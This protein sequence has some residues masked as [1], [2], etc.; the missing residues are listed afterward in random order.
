[1]SNIKTLSDLPEDI[2]SKLRG[3]R[4]KLK[5][6]WYQNDS[7]NICFVNNE[8]TRYFRATRKA[9]SGQ[10]GPFGGGSQ[11]IIS[12]GK[13]LF[14]V[15]QVIMGIPQYEWKKSG[16]MSKSKNGTIIPKVVNTKKEA[17]EIAKSIGIFNI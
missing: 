17:L 12:Y 11:W 6:E 15:G 3:Q 9:L 1:M 13:I 10:Y 16:I 4:L 8:G 14:G 5:D 2:Q 7:Y